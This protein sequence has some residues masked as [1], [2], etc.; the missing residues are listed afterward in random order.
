MLRTAQVYAL[1]Q[2]ACTAA[3]GQKAWAEAH[4]LSA[5]HVNDVL[6]TRREISDRVLAAIGLRRVVRYAQVSISTLGS[7]AA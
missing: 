6:A 7:R 5:Q 4:G 3:G 1:L 2:D